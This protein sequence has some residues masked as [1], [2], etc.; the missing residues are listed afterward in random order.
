MELLYLSHVSWNWTKQRPQFLAEE[1]SNYYKV[2]Y[3]QKRSFQKERIRNNETVDIKRLFRLPLSRYMIVRVVN[4]IL[5]KVQLFFDCQRAEVIWF[6]SP[7]MYS[8]IPYCFFSRKITVYDCMD[9]MIELYPLDKE[10]KKHEQLLYKKA[11]LVF[12]SSLY[13]ANKLKKRYGER[14]IKVINNAISN[15]FEQKPLTLPSNINMH[16]DANEIILTYVGS[17]SSWMDFSLLRKIHERFPHIIINLWGPHDVMIPDQSGINYCGTVNHQF[18]SS[19]L[20][21]SSILIMPFVVNELIRSVNPVKL[22]EYVFSGKPCVA[23]KYGESLQFS[24][25]VFLYDNP[26]ECVTIIGDIING[27]L[28]QRPIDECRRF[29]GN[30]TWKSRTVHIQES[31][32]GVKENRS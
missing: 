2:T 18:V 15:E 4:N 31:I 24:N 19:I 23:P 25:F 11:S 13:L 28:S 9:D 1:L 26:D 16:L 7:E 21:S 3:V 32:Q 14:S 5:F 22:Y 6:T 30:N 27:V 17:I 29:V 10:M 20:S 12:S 8:C